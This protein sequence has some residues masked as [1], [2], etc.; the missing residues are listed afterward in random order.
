MDTE[1]EQFDPAITQKILEEFKIS[2]N[3]DRIAAKLKLSEQYVR[4]TLATVGGQAIR[5]KVAEYGVE[6]VGSVLDRLLVLIKH[7]EPQHMLAASRLLFQIV[8]DFGPSDT[9]PVAA[10]PD[11]VS[12][13]EAVD[14]ID[15]ASEVVDG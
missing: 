3:V 8:K 7:G 1:I 4:Q 11:P 14:Y 9:A 12:F 10:K 13:S 5:E 2:S 15:A 6:L